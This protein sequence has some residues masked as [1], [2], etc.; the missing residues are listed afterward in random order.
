MGDASFFSASKPL[1]TPRQQHG[2]S[3]DVFR[4]QPSPGQGCDCH[5]LLPL[6]GQGLLRQ[7]KLMFRIIKNS[8]RWVFENVI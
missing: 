7:Y 8:T 5:T 2:A 3:G 1:V 6:Q 4:I